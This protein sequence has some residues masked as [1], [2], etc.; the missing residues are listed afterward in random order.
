[1]KNILRMRTTTRWKL[2]VSNSK[3][4]K[5]SQ[6]S[7]EYSKCGSRTSLQVQVFSIYAILFSKKYYSYSSATILRLFLLVH[8]F[9]LKRI[10]WNNSSF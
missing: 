7:H 6:A 5:M 3:Q 10:H 1:M 8:L 9:L 2:I 4:Q